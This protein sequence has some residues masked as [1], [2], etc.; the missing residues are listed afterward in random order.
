MHI[1]W[2]SLAEVAVV[3]AA[4]AL[5]VVLLVDFALVALSAR[6]GKRVDGPAGSPP[7]GVHPGVGTAVAVLCLLAAGLIVGYGLHLIIA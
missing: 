1:D 6:S 7:A 2:A 3:A 4:T 5:T